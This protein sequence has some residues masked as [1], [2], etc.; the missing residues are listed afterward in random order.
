MLPNVLMLLCTLNPKSYKS[1]RFLQKWV[2]KEEESAYS[3]LCVLYVME[4][5]TLQLLI[6]EFKI[7]IYNK[8]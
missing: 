6:Y 4:N 3:R 1:D 8:N 5:D 2:R 7:N